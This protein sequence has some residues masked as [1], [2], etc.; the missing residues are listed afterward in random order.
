MDYNQVYRMFEDDIEIIGE[1]IK[2]ENKVNRLLRKLK[3][4]DS[5]LFFELDSASLRK[6]GIQRRARYTDQQSIMLNFPLFPVYP[7][8]TIR[9]NQEAVNGICC[10]RLEVFSLSAYM[11]CFTDPLYRWTGIG[12]I[13]QY[14]QIMILLFGFI[15]P[16]GASAYFKKTID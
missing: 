7:I 3:A 12:Y 14:D 6:T 11:E 10:D 1:T 16:G 5:E 9:K 15:V 4:K 13:P 8:H 2:A